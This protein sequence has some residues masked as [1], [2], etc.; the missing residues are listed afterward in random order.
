MSDSV[1]VLDRSVIK[2]WPFRRL[3]KG[4]EFE[5]VNMGLK[6]SIQTSREL[7]WSQLNI[8]RGRIVHQ[9]AES[10]MTPS[11]KRVT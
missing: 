8:N 4:E 2:N 9:G 7:V 5:F 11:T 6:F 10:W 3:V 1:I